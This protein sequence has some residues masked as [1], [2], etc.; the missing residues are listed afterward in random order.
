[1]GRLAKFWSLTRIEK[2]FLFEGIILLALSNV[3]LKTVA[4]KHIDWFLRTRWNDAIEGAIGREQEIRLIHCAISRAANVWPWRSLCL[5]RSIAEF[6][7]LRRRRIPAVMF[8]GVRFCSRSSLDAHAW[9]Q[10]DLEM[11]DKN[12][13]NSA[14]TTVIRIGTGSVDRDASCS[15]IDN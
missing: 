10:T 2:R 9:V 6:I 1:M 4:F 14:F 15:K 8:A 13:D 11:S 5:S 7:M 3:C 12:A